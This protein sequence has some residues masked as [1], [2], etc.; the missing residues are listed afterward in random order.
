[1]S[2]PGVLSIDLEDLQIRVQGEQNENVDDVDG[3][4]NKRDKLSYKES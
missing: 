1:V 2:S 3:W 4:V